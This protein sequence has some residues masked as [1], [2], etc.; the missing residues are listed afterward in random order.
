MD[1]ELTKDEQ[2]KLGI[3][4]GYVFRP[5][6]PI[7]EKDLF[8]GRTD[9]V[10]RV[11]DAIFQEGQHVVLYGERGVGKTSLAN[12]L[13]DYVEEVG[14]TILAPHVTCDRTDDFSKLWRKIFG[15]IYV[16]KTERVPGFIAPETS[17]T[18]SMGQ[19]LPINLTP[20][21]VRIHLANLGRQCTLIIIIDEFDRLKGKE[22]RELFAD[23]IKTLSDHAVPVTLIL[24]GVAESVHEL[25]AHHQSIERALIQIHMP[26]MKPQELEEIVTKGLSRV[27]MTIDQ[28]AV[29]R[30]ASLSKGL[31]HYTH[32]VGLHSS[33]IAI[34]AGKRHISL[35]DVSAGIKRALD[36]AQQSI[37]EAYHKATMS[38]RKESLYPSVLLACAMAIPDEFGC[39]AAGDLRE[40][41]N[42][43]TGKPYAIPN[44]ARHLKDLC[45]DSRGPIL[46]MKGTKH[47]LRFHFVDPLMQPFILMKGYAGKEISFDLLD[48][49]T[50]Y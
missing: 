47:R 34:D 7:N 30:L 22:I 37:R 20:N 29:R 23:T 26:R 38:T 36:D 46:K 17:T 28:D 3:N 43:I 41:L 48:R 39:F 11:I 8:A 45:E 42:A 12:V 31:P 32:L 33:R 10:R 19:N 24:V 50:L 40:P 1:A 13:S 27:G 18:V 2:I 9:Q 15:E 49:P 14:K 44:Y 25:I 5:S 6:A 21:D 16:V 35:E 4:V